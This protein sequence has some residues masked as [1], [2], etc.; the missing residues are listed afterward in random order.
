M[1]RKIIIGM[2]FCII[3]I[4]NSYKVQAYS[5]E[6]DPKEYITLPS[7]IQITNGKGT[8]TISVSANG[9]NIS[10]QKND[11]SESTFTSITSKNKEIETYVKT[12][13]KEQKDKETNLTTLKTKHE[14]LVKSG[15]ATEAEIK[16][17]KDAYDKADTE[18]KTFLN[19]VKADSEK[20][21]KEFYNLIP[22]YTNSWTNNSNNI[23]L[24][25]SKSTGKVNFIL[26]V[27]IENGT[28]TYYDFQV[29]SSDI[30]VED[31]KTAQK[32][33]WSNAKLSFE[34]SVPW[35][36]Y[37]NIT[38]VKWEDKHSYYYFIGDE[39]TKPE[40][41]KELPSLSYDKNNNKFST[42]NISKY[43]ELNS[44]QYL[45]VYDEYLEDTKL[46]NKLVL[47]KV[48]IEKPEQK[49]YTDVFWSTYISKD[50]TKININTPWG[51]DTIRNI[52]LRV[53]KI[54]NDTILKNIYNKKSNAF[55]DLLN[56]A[57]NSKAF[58]D[59]TV[60]SNSNVA[61]YELDG[62]LFSESE[63]SDGE[64]YF[65]YVVVEDENG[66]YVKTE[67]VTLARCSKVSSKNNW[68]LLNFYG[69]DDFT[70][71]DF[72]TEGEE[73]N[74]KKVDDNN[75][76]TDDDKTVAKKQL[77]YTGI[78]NI[79]IIIALIIGA[80]GIITYKKYKNYNF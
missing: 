6:I 61:G 65:L 57:R 2:I 1:K 79:L 37:L 47:N 49:K 25:F 33:D 9:Y 76:K 28:D 80:G 73:P 26:W 45:Y 58:Y 35:T 36:Y 14:E 64:Y 46:V 62:A 74:N 78:N 72:T 40:F 44:E 71:K 54:S 56:Y 22:N 63:V 21:Q 41:S 67:G 42:K 50:G 29:Y 48:K 23:E 51:D 7:T 53:G 16:A 75:K 11:I 32:E 77:P 24:D 38:N 59:K 20:L 66:K 55:E 5:G 43:L 12:T 15:K 39:N 34:Q 31:D 18:Y 17:A 68:F 8:G 60:K 27:K 70:W 52:H 30:K 69:N 3:L 4:L 10:Y 19:K 13:E